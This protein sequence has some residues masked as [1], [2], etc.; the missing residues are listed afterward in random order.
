MV[1]FSC[2][3]CQDVIKKPKLDQHRNRCHATFTCIDCNTTFQGTEYRTHTQCIS[4]AEK[5]EKSLYK[6]NKKG[7]KQNGANG[8]ANGVK[9][10]QE[11]T[12]AAVKQPEPIV[13]EIEKGLKRKAEKGSEE[14]EKKEKKQKKEKKEKKDKKDKKEEEKS[15]ETK[16]EEKEKEE[17]EKKEKE[18]KEKKKEKKEKKEKKKEKKDKKSKESEDKMETDESDTGKTAYSEIIPK[19]V[20]KLL[21]KES[22]LSLKALRE[23]TVEMLAKEGESREEISTNFEEHLQLKMENGVVLLN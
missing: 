14:A 5:Y 18:E 9:N 3:A 12:P 4:E 10:T 8:K 21:E 23:K 19:T 15:E 7:N 17:K 11:N 6:G 1:S 20:R 13:S 22:E 16:V 2:D